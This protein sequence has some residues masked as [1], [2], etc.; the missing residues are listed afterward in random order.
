MPPRRKPGKKILKALLPI[1]LLPVVAALGYAVWIVRDAA[2]PPQREYLL[3]PEQLRFS[4]RGLKVTEE[5]WKNRDGTDARGWILRGSEGAPAVLMLHRYEGDRSWVLNLGVK[6]NESTNYTI[7]WPDLRGH[8]KSPPVATTSFGPQESEDVRAALDYLRGLQTPQGQPLV[9][10]RIGIYGVELGAYA[11]LLA[12]RD[13][14]RVRALV[15]DSV[16]QS[17]S[18]SLYGVV[19][20]QVGMDNELLRALTRA[21]SWL[22]FLGGFQNTSSCTVAE[23][24]GERSVLLI[25]GEDAGTLR[26]ATETLAKCFPNPANVESRTDLPLTG[27]NVD[28]A[29]AI[30]SESYA[31]LVIDFFRRTLAPIP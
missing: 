9:G 30:Q 22:Y 23:S 26:A 16:P 4:E 31:N 12:A 5:T 3:T 19:K 27:F 17:A 18:E 10:E 11:G 8:G 13:E 6:I 14:A 21:G 29:T 28:S 24:L 20:G 25:S 7:L 15:L 1:V 2:H